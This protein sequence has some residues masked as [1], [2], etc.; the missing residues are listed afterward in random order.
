MSTED[1]ELEDVGIRKQVPANYG[2]YRQPNG[3]ITAEV[4][5]PFEMMKYREEGWEPLPQYGR[6]DMCNA[7]TAD[8]P[9]ETLF[10][11]GGAKEL[12]VDQIVEAG[13]HIEPLVIPG[14]KQ[15]I[16]QNHKGHKR[17][18]WVGKQS[19]HFPQLKTV[20]P[21]WKCNFC[22]RVS[23]TQKARDQHEGV[24][25]KEEKG[26]IRTGQVLAEALLRGFAGQTVTSQQEAPPAAPVGKGPYA[27]S[28]CSQRFTSLARLKAHVKEHE[29]V[30]AEA[31]A[32]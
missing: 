16:T 7:Y 5:T 4:M 29:G 1:L 22:E 15:P 21:S 20:P 2:Y 28:S 25:H 17:T 3:W 32:V 14:C 13:F 24:I 31:V 19:V 11:F 30:R 26:D 6:F 8:H 12:P 23:P 9:L 27:C 10:M 18:C